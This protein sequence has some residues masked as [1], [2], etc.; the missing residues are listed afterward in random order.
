MIQPGDTGWAFLKTITKMK[1][2]ILLLM[3]FVLLVS[4]SEAQKLV[5]AKP[6]GSK[7]LYTLTPTNDTVTI[8]PKYSASAYVCPVD[9]N[10]YFFV[11]TAASTPLN[12]VY[13]KFTSDATK[14]Y[15]YFKTGFEGVSAVDSIAA[16]KTKV[17]NFMTT[18]AGKFVLLGK[19]AEY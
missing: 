19:S 3:A 14:R 10:L 7:G 15:I 2:I 8:T 4:T 5:S 6:Y 17:Y 9:T 18:T 11:D 1:K 16:N 13:F 12:L